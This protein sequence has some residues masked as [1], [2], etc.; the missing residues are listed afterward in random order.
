[1]TT[2]VLR[3][4]LTADANHT[5]HIVLPPEMGKEVEVIVVPK[6][7]LNP[8]KTVEGFVT[9]DCLDES[10]FVQNILNN[11]EEDCWNEL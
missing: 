9:A 6:S 11:P 3:Q 10:G 2:N 4:Q 8:D 7:S 5:I 1:M